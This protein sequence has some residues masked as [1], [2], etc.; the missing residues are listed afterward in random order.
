MTGQLPFGMAA[1]NP[2]WPEARWNLTGLFVHDL[3]T[4]QVYSFLQDRFGCRLDIDSIHGAPHVAWNCGRF[5]MVPPPAPKALQAMVATFNDVG[6]GVYFTFTN[7]LLENGDLDDPVCNGLLE[8]IDN[9]RDLNGVILASDALFDHVLRRHPNLKLTASII[10]VTEER[11]RGDLAYY[12]SALSRFDSVMI[13]PDDGFNYE[14]LSEIDPS[15][16]N[17]IEILVNENCAFGC[18]NR[19]KDYQVMASVLKAGIPFSDD[20]P[21]T[22]ME[23]RHCRMPLK[24]LT[25]AVRSCNFAARE[26]LK[27]YELG[28]RRFKLQGRQDQPQTFLFD[29]LRF[30]IEPEVLMPVVFKA[31]VSGQAGRLAAK[32]VSTVRTAWQ[33][34]DSPDVALATIVA[35]RHRDESPPA[36]PIVVETPV[37]DAHRLPTGVDTRHPLWP[38]ARWAIGGLFAHGPVIRD[39]LALLTQRFDYPLNVDC[40]CGRPP[41]RWNATQTTNAARPN[42]E[43]IADTIEHYNEMGIGVRCVLSGSHV[44]PA[45][46]SD[47]AGNEI[48]KIL[49]RA[50]G[51]NGVELVSDVLADY[52]R[53]R[54][55]QL[56]LT[57]TTTPTTPTEQCSPPRDARALAERFD[58]VVLS[59]Q[60]GFDHHLLVQ[61]DRDRTEIVVNDNRVWSDG[62]GHAATWPNDR[63]QDPLAALETDTRL[64]NFTT[65]ELKQVYDLGYRRFRLQGAGRNT[66][67][68][69]YDV[70]RYM[71]EP[72]LMLPVVF[73]SFS[74]GWAREQA[75]GVAD[76]LCPQTSP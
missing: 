46:L 8:S 76:K 43:A 69:F 28:Y 67:A 34:A 72:G 75:G 45:D 73:K 26:M 15:H 68:F 25:P 48:L 60:D 42:V 50:P 9:G 3:L 55:P 22:V 33:K 70:L 44:T 66:S 56:K 57:A 61:L 2:L 47:E 17:R 14:M 24:T 62:S 13:H 7:H 27:V 20:N 54:Y 1:R 29:L 64:S 35:D 58:T 30:S 38:D 12:Q 59:A 74:N 52:I 39:A 41:L 49:V 16:R 4:L 63:A 40:V 37:V 11:G 23:R 32:A 19:V 5:S 51:L 36:L 71:L 10:K 21:Y 31:F 53:S 65:E 6:I 18:P